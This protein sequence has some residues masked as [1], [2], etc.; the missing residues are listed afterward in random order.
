MRLFVTGA[1]GLLGS[2][3]AITAKEAGHEVVGLTRRKSEPL[4]EILDEL[5]VRDILELTAADVPRGIDA[6]VHFA[7]GTDGSSEHIA[8]VAVEGTL[9]VLE[10]TRS[11]GVHRFVHVSSMSVYGANSAR[12]PVLEQRPQRR[13]IYARSKTL[14]D[15]ALQEVAR[16]QQFSDVELIIVRPGL[17]FARD[18]KDPL[19]GTAVDLPLG[20]KIGLGRP[21]QAVP[22]VDIRELSTGLV[23][24]LEQ[25][26]RQSGVVRAFDVLSPA[27][28]TKRHFLRHYRELTGQEGPEIWIPYPL[29]IAAAALIDR[30]P[31]RMAPK[32]VGYNIRR[33]YDFDAARL[34]YRT[35]WRE[36]H[37][38]RITDVRDTLALALTIDRELTPNP[39]EHERLRRVATSL[40]RVA[41]DRCAGEQP[42]AGIVLVGAG[43]IVSEMHVPVLRWLSDVDVRAVVDPNRKAAGAIATQVGAA[44]VASALDEVPSELLDGATAVVATPGATHSQLVAQLLE[45]GLP[46]LVEKP[47]VLLRDEFLHLR[48]L[49]ERVGVPVTVFHNYRLR[50]RVLDLWRFLAFHDVG[51]LVKVSVQFHAPRIVLEQARWTHD[52]KRARALVMEKAIHF[53]DLAVAMGG[54]L[55]SLAHSRV[56]DRR[57][58]SSTV[59]FT[60]VGELAS[61]A[62]LHFDLDLSGT[63]TRVAL[64]ADFE[65]AACRLRFYPDVFRVLRRRDNPVDDVAAAARRLAGALYHRARPF[66][67]GLP[68]RTV[69]H[70]RIY[71]E[72]F[73]RVGTRD[74]GGPFSLD[75]VSDTM[76]SLFLLSD[77]AYR[78]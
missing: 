9:R 7:T 58:R 75:C 42:R 76:E 63:A 25:E 3:F 2:H 27:P 16:T 5:V 53:L 40:L 70:A 47:L 18:M 8:S 36:V 34:P 37:R 71:V 44:D 13:G 73:G 31:S 55:T 29:A 78:E 52:E 38:P 10:L 57:E 15:A 1:S 6:A 4:A 33:L 59:S 23:R 69:P 21:S 28:P 26:E 41:Q 49:V 24:L 66:E 64:E 51:R 50:P 12:E 30:V 60:G 74:R 22:V 19:A 39:R 20:V 56:I 72:H 67:S 45:R 77:A 35:F 48:A 43:R 61:G 32:N 65:R 54:R 68:R 17:V 46:V 62:E 11:R 14:A